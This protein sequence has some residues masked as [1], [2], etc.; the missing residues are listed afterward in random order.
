M[1]FGLEWYPAHNSS[2]F[3]TSLW[4]D[5]LH[6]CLHERFLDGIVELLTP[7]ASEELISWSSF[8]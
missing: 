7:V 1:V 5:Y 6:G 2:L 3:A 8:D 4:C